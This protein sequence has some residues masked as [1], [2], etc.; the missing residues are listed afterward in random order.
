MVATKCNDMV[1]HMG[2]PPIGK[3]AMTATERSHRFRAKQRAE[4]PAT[5]RNESDAA[6]IAALNARIA[7]LEAFQSTLAGDVVAVLEEKNR[8][9]AELESKL[10]QRAKTPAPSAKQTDTRPAT[11]DRG[12]AGKLIRRLGGASAPSEILAAARALA[13]STD[14]HELAEVWE[15]H[16]Q[17][18]NKH[19][20]PKPKPID[21]PQVEAAIRRYADGKTNLKINDLL[22]S[23]FAKIPGLRE[24]SHA[25]PSFLG[26]IRGCLHHLGFTASR[27]GLTYDRDAATRAAR[28]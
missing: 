23:V 8:R 26:Y 10:A 13:K 27:S 14:L 22:R 12:N 20:P 6:T 24:A 18:K 5:K 9:I 25:E 15:K 1:V 7:E 17:K 11:E 28:K 21:W 19:K 16:W 4:Q 3:V 2:R